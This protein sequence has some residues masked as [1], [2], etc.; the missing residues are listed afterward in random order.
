[1]S[2]SV[3]SR[4]VHAESAMRRQPGSLN[5]DLR[6]FRA[7]VRR[8]LA[9]EFVPAQPRWEQQQH[10]DAA[11]WK[12]AGAAGLLLADVP[13]QYGGGG[14]TIAHE[15]VI[16]EELAHAGLHF[17]FSVQSVVAHYLLSY[18]TEAQ[19]RSWLPRMARGE[20]VGAI[21][22]TEPSAGS[23]L[24]AIRTAALRDGRDYAIDGSKTFISNGSLAG[25]VALAVKTDPAAAGLRGISLIMVETG[26]LPGYRV[27]SPLRKI[28]Q[29]GLDTCEL[30]FDNVRVPVANLLGSAEG[31]GFSQI[32]SQ[33]PYERLL[34]AIGALAT[35]EKAVA[36]TVEHVR[37]RTAFGMPLFGHQNTRFQLAECKTVAH[38]GRAFIERCIQDAANGRLDATDAAM[39]KYWLTEWEGRILDTCLQLHGGY[40]YMAE[41]PIARMWTGSRVH[42]IYA[43]SNEIMKEVIAAS[44]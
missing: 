17:G 4:P 21:A 10:P 5:E 27:G 7:T 14:G 11:D 23:D 44:L 22:L 30:F 31:L 36:L 40:G 33:L 13:E 12:R 37:D 25:L 34:V 20:L 9:E 28:G 26:N 35:A 2:I 16:A 6:L 1:M 41:S 3:L 42:R 32:I 39:A 38:I 19:K 18:G 8:F 15:A 24:Q 43:G 29:H